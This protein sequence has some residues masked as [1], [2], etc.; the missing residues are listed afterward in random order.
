MANCKINIED[1]RKRIADF[2]DKNGCSECK[3]SFSMDI[4]YDVTYNYTTEEIEK[5]KC[6]FDEPTTGYN[7]KSDWDIAKCIEVH[8]SD[9]SDKT[10]NL[11]EFIHIVLLTT[12]IEVDGKSYNYSNY[13]KTNNY[14]MFR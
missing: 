12:K 11:E 4:F 5:I 10:P 1:F 2:L 3:E 13:S 9:I 6:D 7:L 14:F 8:Y